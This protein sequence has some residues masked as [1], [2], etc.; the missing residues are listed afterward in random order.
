MRYQGIVDLLGKIGDG[1]AS[2]V[3]YFPALEQYF[4]GDC[5]RCLD[6]LGLNR[7]RLDRSGA[8]AGLCE[9]PHSAVIMNAREV[10]TCCKH[11][12]WG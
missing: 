3:A 9:F 7:E 10:G 12:S 2:P 5:L 1:L 4:S 6:V 8:A 11:T